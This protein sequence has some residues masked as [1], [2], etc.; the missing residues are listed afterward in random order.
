MRWRVSVS[1]LPDDSRLLQE[2][3][4]PLGFSLIAEDSGD[5]LVGDIFEP[6]QSAEAVYKTATHL[7]EVASEIERGDPAAQCKFKTGSVFERAENG[8]WR[9]HAFAKLEARAFAIATATGILSV[10][11]SNLS[12]E[13]G[14]RLEQRRKELEF[15]SLR[16]RT[17]PKFASA[18]RYPHALQVQ[19]LLRSE[20]DPLTLG[21]IADIVEDDLGAAITQLSSRNQWTRFRRSI[22]HP[23]VFGVNARHIVSSVE[24]PPDPMTLDEAQAFVRDIARQWLIIK[25]T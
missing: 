3:L 13:E 15:R 5:F 12:E 7:E 8:S 6:E 24:P 22:N 2:L 25:G 14:L 4:A 20:L 1:S 11:T 18:F 10:S 23:D 17:V 9:Q 16:E 21:H 19:Q